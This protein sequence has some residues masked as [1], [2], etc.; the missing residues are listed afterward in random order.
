MGPNGLHANRENS[1][2]TGRMSFGWFCHAQA[3]IE[4][5]K[6]LIGILLS[7]HYS[8]NLILPTNQTGHKVINLIFHKSLGLLLGVTF[9]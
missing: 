6:I 2:Q 8:L 5:F 7:M 3:Q 4:S 9:R 1:D